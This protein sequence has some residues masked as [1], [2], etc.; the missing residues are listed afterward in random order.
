MV[1]KYLPY[2]YVTGEGG[3]HIFIKL[4]Y[5]L[6]ARELLNL[7]FKDGVVFMEGSIF[8][9]NSAPSDTFRIGF[10][11]V[12]DEDIETGIKIIGKT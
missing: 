5:N 6:N 4:K 9:A 8:Y 7:C 11:R 12:S 1:D 3:L 2:E 10:G